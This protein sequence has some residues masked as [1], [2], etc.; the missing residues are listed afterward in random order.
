MGFITLFWPWAERLEWAER[1]DASNP[2]G[3]S[4]LQRYLTDKKTHPP[5]TLP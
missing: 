4:C 3:S 1:L 2:A 5:R